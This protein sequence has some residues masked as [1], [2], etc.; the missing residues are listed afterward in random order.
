MST[1]KPYTIVAD[2][3]FRKN[4]NP[5]HG[6]SDIAGDLETSPTVISGRGGGGDSKTFCG[7]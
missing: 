4:S 1:M 5:K 3:F 7:S 6:N 2:I